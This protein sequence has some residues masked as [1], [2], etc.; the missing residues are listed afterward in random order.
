MIYRCL[1][2]SVLRKESSLES[3]EPLA[4]KNGG[5]E[6]DDVIECLDGVVANDEIKLYK[7]K[8]ISLDG[9]WP[10]ILV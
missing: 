1:M 2:T 10:I 9:E 4:K 3:I 8:T 5:D 6:F 7:P